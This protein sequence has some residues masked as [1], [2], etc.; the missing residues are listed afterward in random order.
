MP[1]KNPVI[2][3]LG[4]DI[5]L[6]CQLK[7]ETVLQTVKIDVQWILDKSPEKINVVSYHG[8]NNDGPWDDRF[9][10]R[11]QLSHLDLKKGNMSLIL[12]GGQISDQGKYICMISLPNWYDEVIVDLILTE[13][14]AEP[15]I[16]LVDYQGQ[17]IGLTCSSSGWYPEPQVFWLDGGGKKLIKKSDTRITMAPS[18]TET[19]SVLSSLTL[20]PGISSEVVCKIVNNILQME[21]E[22]RILITEEFYPT[23]SPWLPP[24]ILILAIFIGIMVFVVYKLRRS[25]LNVSQVAGEQINTLKH[26]EECL[27]N[28]IETEKHT[29]E[30]SLCELQLQYG[31]LQEEL[32]F[33][34]ARSYAAAITLD[35]DYKHPDVVIQNNLKEATLKGP[36]EGHPEATGGTLIVVGK[37]GYSS[38]KHYWEVVVG[39]R[40][41]WE[42]GVL[43]QSERDKVKKEKFT[44]YPGEGCW[45]MRSSRGDIFS[46]P[47]DSK[48]VKKDVE[49]KA[50]GLLLDQDAEE[51]FFYNAQISYLIHSIPIQSAERLYPFLSFGSAAEAR[52]QR[53]LGIVHL[54][55]I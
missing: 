43:T 22:S 34:R 25:N 45:A 48:I 4:R 44:G 10:G 23:I 3:I 32:G 46:I 28:G 11:A 35:S 7:T 20:E 8:G 50:I 12:K 55:V 37:E 31:T 15:T 1:P 49:H 27:K 16:S 47:G 29:T 6:P 53:P 18:P 40:L 30:A 24:F 21:S 41:E 42:L 14:G 54:K 36:S 19:F 26:E 51:I 17:G 5:L 33:R 9:Q 38:G 2:G 52:D 13:N 39:D